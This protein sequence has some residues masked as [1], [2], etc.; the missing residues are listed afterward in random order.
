M[1]FTAELDTGAFYTIH[2]TS[3]KKTI[4]INNFYLDMV[5]DFIDFADVKQ[6]AGRLTAHDQR[7][8]ATFT[9]GSY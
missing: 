5:A 6:F 8:R 7:I 3:T 2:S 9:N 1:A 4:L